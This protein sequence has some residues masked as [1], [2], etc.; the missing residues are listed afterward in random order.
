MIC[1]HLASAEAAAPQSTD[2]C[3]D[4]LA[5]GSRDWVHL[6]LCL[7]CGR[8]SCCDSS[9]RKHATAHW[10]STDHPVVRSF[11]PAESWRWCY[12]DE[13]VG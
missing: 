10:H 13:A 11:Q 8:V 2:G 5:D 12:V 4:C 3:Q 6:R 7:E 1:T 9:P